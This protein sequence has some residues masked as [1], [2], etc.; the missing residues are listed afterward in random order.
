MGKPKNIP[1]LR[2]LEYNGKWEIKK[3]AEISS[4]LDGRRKPIK[5]SDR[6]KMKGEYPYYG[7]S[8][9][10]D[11]VND[12]IFDEEIILLGE[13]GENIISR[14]LPLAFR[15]SGKCW[16]NNH[17][18]VIK[19][20]IN[21]DIDFLTISLESISYINYNTGTAQPKLNQ[22]VCKS[23]PIALPSLHEQQKI[24]SFFTALDKKIAQLKRKKELLENYKKGVMQKLFS[25]EIR[26]KDENGK[27]FPE[28]EDSRLGDSTIKVDR[29]NKEKMML[30]VYSINN[31]EGFI[32]QGDQFEGM[33]SVNRGFDIS[34]Y[35][36]IG[37]STFAYNPARINVG[38]IGYS[39]E[40]EDIII[41]SL[42]VCFK[43]TDVLNDS[44]LLQFLSTN[45]FKKAVLRYQ[46][47]GVRD[48]LFYDNFSKIRIALPSL[49]EQSK[50]ANFLT[51]IDNK[52]NSAST[53]IE[54]SE[55]YKKGLLQKMFV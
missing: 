52:I 5:E 10:I 24:A 11:Y 2:F 16:V 9:I 30:P 36:I 7:A 37:S 31:K 18:H 15:V 1:E 32:P 3:L 55:H 17:A 12:Y 35:K 26:F 23:I 51:S 33:D 28:W 40:L 22:Q 39:Y 53:Q 47:G 54:Q 43:T 8:G 20:N 6:A 49:S 48:Y 34:L 50:I 14:N 46:E 13:D 42:Y 4:F 27:E 25:R 44:Y 19:A 38:S 45:F 41:S 29:K 21:T